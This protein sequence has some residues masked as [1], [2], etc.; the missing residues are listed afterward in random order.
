MMRQSWHLALRDLRQRQVKVMLAALVI[1]VTTVAGIQ[2]F[3]GGLQQALV[4]SASEFLAADRQLRSRNSEPIAED[5]YQPAASL[6][7][8]TAKMTTFS[9][10]VSNGDAFQLT[11]VKAVSDAYPLLGQLEWQAS[12][13]SPTQLTTSG[14]TAGEVWLSPRLSRLLTIDVGDTVQVGERRLQVS[15]LLV[16]EPDSGFNLSALAPRLMMHVDDVA[17]TEV[18]QPGSRVRYRALFAGDE[19]ALAAMQQWLKPRL[20]SDYRWV[21]VRD[22]DTLSG[23]LDK[24]EDFLLLGGSLAV[25]LAVLAIAVAA[26][27]YASSQRDQ[28]AL[29]K[30]LG[31]TGRQITRAYLGRLA[32]WGLL[33][34]VV[35]L[36]L[37]FGLAHILM[38]LAAA[39]LER[40]LKPAFSVWSLWPAISTVLLAMVLFA[41]PP[42]SRLRHIPAMRVLRSLPI[43]V[44]RPFIVQIGLAIISVFALLWAYVG[45]VVLVGTLLL[46]VL[47]LTGLLWVAGWLVLKLISASSPASGV[48]GM[49]LKNMWRH[50]NATLSQ[51]C[52]FAVTVML[53]ATLL[54]SRSSLLADWQSQLPDNAPNHFLL[55]IAERSLPAVNTFIEN[56]A[57]NRSDLYPIVRGRLTHINDTAVADALENHNEIGALNRELS[58]TAAQ[59]VPTDNRITAGQWFAPTQ[60]D[61]LSI[62]S[63]LA[64]RLDVGVGDKLGFRVGEQT[65]TETVT[66]IRTLDWDTLR[67]NFYIIFADNGPLEA[68]PRTWLTA[69]FLPPPDKAMLDDFVQEFPTISILEIDHIIDQIQQIIQQVTR[70][71]EAIL[72]MVL[73]AAVAVMVAVV[74]ATISER[75]REGALMRTLGAQQKLLTRTTVIEFAL[76]GL[77]AG[78]MGVMAAELVVWILQYRLFEGEFRWHPILIVILPL[79]TAALLV[80]LGRWQL[81]PVLKVSPMRLLRKLE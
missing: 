36:L 10:M 51:I 3:A 19:P 45:D 9:T 74:S 5:V 24:A 11:A 7:L 38:Q 60:Q 54:L 25:L 30:T 12:A 58:L 22:G 61:G 76:I 14:P 53:A 66:S 71:V 40:P 48:M 47:V 6:N 78:V 39:M 37:A 23:S 28:V 49:A 8:R 73:L 46:G 42:I 56:N 81:Q 44:S 63:S 34:T 59:Q 43:S 32:V 26:R 77:L 52:V 17:A 33:A 2:L 16:R 21:D 35:G 65:F 20:D 50:R 27:E 79:M 70:A 41:Y 57:S 4:T 1:A 18:I 55:N 13:E 68:L 29:L 69:F 31:Q 75:Q 72:L 62:E 67:P 64:E 15:G 80:L